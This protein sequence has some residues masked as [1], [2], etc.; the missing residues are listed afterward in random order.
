MKKIIAVVLLALI[1]AGCRTVPEFRPDTIVDIPL[2]PTQSETQVTETVTEAPT[3]TEPVTEAPTEPATE[4]PT[5]KPKGSSSGK[6]NTGKK[7]ASTKPTET[8][9][10]KPTEKSTEPPT[11]PPTEAPTE[12]PTEVPTE[13]PTEPPTQAPTRPSVSTYSPTALDYSIVDT[14]NAHRAE[15]GL[16]SLTMDSR[17]CTAAAQRAR[18]LPLS[19]S[20]TRPGGSNFTTVLA[21]LGVAYTFAAENLYNS[22][23]SFTADTV[24]SKWMNSDSH[25]AN[26]LS[27]QAASIGVATHSAD[28]FTYIAALI[29]G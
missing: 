1:L 7:P 29:V 4:K 28:G 17:L 20:H 2:E 19:W 21:D 10:E 15:A 18:E 25:R 16:P 6:E 24:V 9:A 5:E 3:E 14:I 13:P 27:E 12:A 11:Q 8:A 23:L 26:L 22:A